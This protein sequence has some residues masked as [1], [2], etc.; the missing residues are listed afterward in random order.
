MSAASP[1]RS[2][3]AVL[4]LQERADAIVAELLRRND[5]RWV[6]LGERDRERVELVARTVARRLLSAPAAR[7]DRAGIDGD[8]GGYVEAARELFALDADADVAM[9]PRGRYRRGR[10]CGGIP[11]PP[12]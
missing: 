1:I 8:A 9:R 10:A 5:G 4:A 11:A 7:L 2:V 6:A 3:P 12:T